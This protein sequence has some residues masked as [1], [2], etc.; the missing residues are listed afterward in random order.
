MSSLNLSSLYIFHICFP[1]VK[2]FASIQN[3]FIESMDAYPVKIY[4]L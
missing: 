1:M 4:D 2:I 3:I